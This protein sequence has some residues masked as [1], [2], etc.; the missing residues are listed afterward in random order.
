MENKF[1]MGF[2]RELGS[3]D[4]DC[5]YVS[6]GT[7]YLAVTVLWMW[8]S[9]GSFIRQTLLEGDSYTDTGSPVDFKMHTLW[10][11]TQI[12]WNK[13]IIILRVAWIWKLFFIKCY[14]P[15]QSPGSRRW[16]LFTGVR[17]I[18]KATAGQVLITSSS[19]F[20]TTLLP[21]HSF[22]TGPNRSSAGL[23]SRTNDH[24]STLHFRWAWPLNLQLNL[25][26]TMKFNL[27]LWTRE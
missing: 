25:I 12:N 1:K 11:G 19:A 8:V 4:V 16:N 2:T 20:I 22:V 3:G 27:H 17:F 7:E 10:A 6:Q 21:T 18:S 14:K 15:C 9:G 23:N 26:S 24:N 5:Q 13:K